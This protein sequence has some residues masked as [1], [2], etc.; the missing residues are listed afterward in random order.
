MEDSREGQVPTLGAD[1]ANL[2]GAGGQGSSG[3]LCKPAPLGGFVFPKPDAQSK[4][5]S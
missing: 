3:H 4:D 1:A 2:L 5:E